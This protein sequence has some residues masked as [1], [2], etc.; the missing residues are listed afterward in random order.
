[1][2]IGNKKT[3]ILCI[4][5]IIFCMI[6]IFCMSAEDAGDSDK[7][8]GFFV[9]L[10]SKLLDAE[11]TDSLITFVRK[12]AHMFEFAALGISVL[13]LLYHYKLSNLCRILYSE[14]FVILY[15][16]TDEIHQYF[17]PGRACRFTDI[18]IDSLG[19][20]IGIIFIF[21]VIYFRLKRREK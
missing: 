14:G 13:L 9:T 20:F 15:A 3:K 11:Q 12:L 8:S 16:I 1:M 17:V 5:F 18:C 19:G 6:F 2:T 21:A 7:T 4:A 10:V